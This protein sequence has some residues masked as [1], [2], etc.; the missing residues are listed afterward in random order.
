MCESLHTKPVIGWSYLAL[1]LHQAGQLHSC[2][3]PGAAVHVAS[4]TASSCSCHRNLLGTHPEAKCSCK[5]I[6]STQIPGDLLLC[7]PGLYE[8]KTLVKHSTSKLM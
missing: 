3:H 1:Q 8:L 4:S 5:C 7:M 6:A 2:W